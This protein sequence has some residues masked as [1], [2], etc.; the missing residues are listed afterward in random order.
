MA[1]SAFSSLSLRARVRWVWWWCQCWSA[2][3]SPAAG[4]CS[5]RTIC[6]TRLYLS[7]RAFC[8]CSFF[9]ATPC[10]GASDS[11]GR[12]LRRRRRMQLQ[13]EGLGAWGI[14]VALAGGAMRGSIPYMFVSLGE[15]LTEKSGKINLG[16]EGVLLMGAMT[17][18]AISELTGSPWLGVLAAAGVG[19]LLG[20]M[21]AWLTQQPAVND[22]AAGIAMIIFGSG[23]AFFFGKRFVAPMAPQLPLV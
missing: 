16:M 14:A 19:L 4:C 10:T 15:C 23:L 6:R 1:T 13:P 17:A 5:A 2:D 3:F 22:V 11:R 12:S 8:S 18:F 7:C 21:H 9:S 20:A